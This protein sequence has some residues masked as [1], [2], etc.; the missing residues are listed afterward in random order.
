MNKYL[1]CSNATGYATTKKELIDLATVFEEN[2]LK[3]H[4]F[5]VKIR[6]QSYFDQELSSKISRQEIKQHLHQ[7]IGF[8]PIFCAKE[9]L[10]EV[11]ILADLVQNSSSSEFRFPV[12]RLKEILEGLQSEL[13]VWRGMLS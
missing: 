4:N 1:D 2:L 6:S 9:A 10:N 5:F 7:L 12:S 8:L 11:I 3:E 13:K